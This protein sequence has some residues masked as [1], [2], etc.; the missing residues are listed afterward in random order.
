MQTFITVIITAWLTM[1]ILTIAKDLAER[2]S[3]GKGMLF[4]IF[5]LAP[6]I[7]ISEIIG[8]REE[9]NRRWREF[10]KRWPKK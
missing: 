7:M 4:I 5:I 2:N 10:Y 3:R 6:I 9:E 8:K 1:S